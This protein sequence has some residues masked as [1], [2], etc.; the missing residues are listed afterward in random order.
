MMTGKARTMIGAVIGLPG[1]S[2]EWFDLKANNVHRLFDLAQPPQILRQGRGEEADRWTIKLGRIVASLQTMGAQG[3]A[4]CEVVKG[5]WH[6]IH[7]QHVE[8]LGCE[9]GL[10]TTIFPLSCT[11]IQASGG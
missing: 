6:A 10:S 9:K 8:V 1:W 4:L 7:H 3:I 2:L 5:S 11:I